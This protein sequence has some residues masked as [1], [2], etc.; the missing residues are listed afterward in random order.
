M[1][2]SEACKYIRKVDEG[3]LFRNAGNTPVLVYPYGTFDAVELAADELV[4]YL[5]LN[6]DTDL[7]EALWAVILTR[8]GVME[9]DVGTLAV[10]FAREA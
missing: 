10:R 2:K 6:S 5:H 8:S 7:V 4:I 9:I 1:N 3:S